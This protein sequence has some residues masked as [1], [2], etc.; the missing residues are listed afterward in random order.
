MN[1]SNGNNKNKMLNKYNDDAYVIE[2]RKIH[3]GRDIEIVAGVEQGEMYEWDV[4]YVYR[5]YDMDLYY[6]GEGCGC[7][8]TWY[9]DGAGYGDLMQFTSRRA[10][11]TYL[12]NS[13]DEKLKYLHGELAKTR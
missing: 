4:A 3:P 13:D 10:V 12:R 5:V 1:N 6:V 8:C 11:L 9:E 7:S 2:L